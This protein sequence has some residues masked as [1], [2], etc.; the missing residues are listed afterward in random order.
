MPVQ[1]ARSLADAIGSF[2]DLPPAAV[3]WCC[4]G[5][6]LFCLLVLPLA[7]GVPLVALAASLPWWEE[8]L[9]ATR[10]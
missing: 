2:F 1:L 8:R 9:N 5:F 6:T 10:T 7:I 4:I 3:I